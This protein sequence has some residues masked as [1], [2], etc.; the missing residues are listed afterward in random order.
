MG[1]PS[2]VPPL[3]VLSA[4]ATV[5]SSTMLE[6]SFKSEVDEVCG[7][8]APETDG[9]SLVFRRRE[10]PAVLARSLSRASS[11]VL[12]IR[13][14]K[15]SSMALNVATACTDTIRF[16]YARGISS[17][18]PVSLSLN[19]LASIPVWFRRISGNYDVS[20]CQLWTV[21]WPTYH[22]SVLD[23]ASLPQM[24]PICL[25]SLAVCWLE[26]EIYWWSLL[27]L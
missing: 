19:C 3:V 2:E 17:P 20:V 26:H 15:Y 8:L 11:V 23:R 13:G 6:A 9:E 14:R 4:D 25:R 22:Q 5:S 7:V 27:W 21:P 10:N 24:S 1:F 16:W 12:D 18:S